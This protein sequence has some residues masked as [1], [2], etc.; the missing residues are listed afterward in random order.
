MK[1]VIV[2]HSN[3]PEN[4]TRMPGLM[5]AGEYTGDSPINGSML[6]GEKAAEAVIS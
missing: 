5:L 3:L 6:S 2:I 1:V 4:R